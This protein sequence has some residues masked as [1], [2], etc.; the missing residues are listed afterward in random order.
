MASPRMAVQT[1]TRRQ[2]VL[3]VGRRTDDGLANTLRSRR[4][5]VHV[6]ADAAHALRV[7]KPA[8][9]DVVLIDVRKHLPGEVIDFCEQIKSRWPRQRIAYLTGPPAYV[10]LHW[11]DEIPETHTPDQWEETVHW[12]LTAA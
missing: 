12:F 11:P 4:M 8:T 10:T 1:S 3:I 2:H 6:S 7:W 9:Y 5:S